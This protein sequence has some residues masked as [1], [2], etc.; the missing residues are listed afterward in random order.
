[1]GNL[2]PWWRRQSHDDTETIVLI[3]LQVVNEQGALI[4]YVLVRDLS[5]S[6]SVSEAPYKFPGGHQKT[7]ETLEEAIIRE[8]LE[9]AGVDLTYFMQTLRELRWWWEKGH[10][11]HLFIGT[12]DTR[13]A[14]WLYNPDEGRA[15][16]PPGNE[17]ERA[18]F[19]TPHGFQHLLDAGQ[20]LAG[21]ARAL[22]EIGLLDHIRQGELIQ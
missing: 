18:Y 13:A 4:G 8:A 5:Q 3:L 9:E 7:G 10:T 1:M 11:K 16:A 14:G 20:V 17:G 2:F 21:H 15:H 19:I 6:L 22:Q 12:V